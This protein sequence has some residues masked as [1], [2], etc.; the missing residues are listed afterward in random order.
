[1]TRATPAQ[2]AKDLLTL[3]HGACFVPADS[4]L[5]KPF[6]AMEK[7]GLITMTA[8][9]Q[10]QPPG[11]YV[12]S[13]LDFDKAI[14]DLEPTHNKDCQLGDNWKNCPACLAIIEA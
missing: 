1:M 12:H 6:R 11:F 3:H 9:P 14:S 2:R 7:A 4:T 10:E 5:V 8:T 13:I